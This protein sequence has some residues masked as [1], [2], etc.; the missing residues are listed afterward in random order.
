MLVPGDP[1]YPG[2]REVR[3]ARVGG[4]IA[5]LRVG[6]VDAGGGTTRWLSI[7]APAEGYYL[8]QL[9]W[10]GNSDELMVEKL[11]RFRDKREFLIANVRTGGITT[12][13]QES[14][15]AWVISSLRR[16]SGLEWI[17]GLSL[18]HI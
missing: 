2:V 3:Y 16:N 1:T 5:T 9:S 17:N 15:P 14:D 18:I 10:V 4:T 8:G 7:Q 6:V 11:S 13:F 12:M